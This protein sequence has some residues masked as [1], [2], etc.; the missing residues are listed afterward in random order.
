MLGS[1][2]VYFIMRDSTYS[3]KGNIKNTTEFTNS[4]KNML[5]CLCSVFTFLRFFGFFGF[6]ILPTLH[7]TVSI[8]LFQMAIEFYVRASNNI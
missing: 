5:Y 7:P 1:G 3:W 2:T 6:S 8:H 4:V